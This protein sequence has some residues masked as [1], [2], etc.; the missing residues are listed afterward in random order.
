MYILYM[1]I[2]IF[3]IYVYLIY[4]YIIYIERDRYRYTDI[5]IYR[6]IDIYSVHI[7][8]Y[9]KRLMEKCVEKKYFA[10]QRLNVGN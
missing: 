2:Y 3:I 9:K 8:Y 4:I 5:Q 10:T 6:Y 1:Y 7:P